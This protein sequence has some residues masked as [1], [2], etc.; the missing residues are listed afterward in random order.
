ME[1]FDALQTRAASAKAGICIHTATSVTGAAAPV[2]L[3]HR[4][5][6]RINKDHSPAPDF[7]AFFRGPR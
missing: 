4:L 2:P 1:R 6:A 7:K 3:E 5:K